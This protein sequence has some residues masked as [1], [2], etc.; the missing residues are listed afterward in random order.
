MSAAGRTRFEP[1]PLE[2]QGHHHIKTNPLA[3]GT[4]WHSPFTRGRNN[5]TVSSLKR[6]SAIGISHQEPC[7]IA[8]HRHAEPSVPD[9]PLPERTEKYAPLPHATITRQFSSANIS[10][11]RLRFFFPRGLAE[12]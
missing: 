7:G 6:Y 8:V 3:N 11:R 1:C 12:A 5:R 2:K 9:V 4:F 10:E